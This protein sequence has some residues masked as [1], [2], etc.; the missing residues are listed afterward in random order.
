MKAMILAA[1][2]GTRLRP[3]TYTLPKP[4]VPVCN[5]PL[6]AYAM[7][8]FLTAG[9][10]DIVV[11]LHHLPDLLE[12]DLRARFGSDC[13]LELSYEPKILG[14]GGGVRRV[15][16]LLDDGDDF[17]LANGD[18]I[19]FPRWDRLVEQRPRR[20]ALRGRAPRHPA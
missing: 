6:I 3:L 8:A 11:N 18:T 13:R 9:I 16:T 7:E 14:T 20:G 15:R 5:R 4:M 12:R 2:Y 10:R 1:G 17:L 19:Q